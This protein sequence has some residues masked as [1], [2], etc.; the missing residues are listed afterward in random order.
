MPNPMVSYYN[1]YGQVAYRCY[2]LGNPPECLWVG[3]VYADAISKLF[4]YYHAEC[5]TMTR[6]KM[7]CFIQNFI[8]DKRKRRQTINPNPPSLLHKQ[9]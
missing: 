4:F 7:D 9:Q 5:L 6:H 2:S 3:L 1:P 8:I